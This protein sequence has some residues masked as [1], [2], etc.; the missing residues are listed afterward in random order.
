MQERVEQVALTEEPKIDDISK[1]DEKKT[2]STET[3]I[4]TI[5]NQSDDLTLRAAMYGVLF[6]SYA[7]QVCCCFVLMA[8]RSNACFCGF[9]H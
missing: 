9:A 2:P 3:S 4:S 5:D 1:K 6:Q 8:P 7:D